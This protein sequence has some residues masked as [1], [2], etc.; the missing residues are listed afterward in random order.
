MPAFLCVSLLFLF[1]VFS[2]DR[3]YK[4]D[5]SIRRTNSY[6]EGLRIVTKKDGAD[7]WIMT[8]R[9]ADFTKDETTAR[10]DSVSMDIKKEGVL[11]NAENGTYNMDNKDLSLE[12]N[13]TIRAK[14]SIIRMKSLEW[15]P[16]RG[17]LTS[18]SNIRVENSRFTVEGEGLSAT[19][20]NKVTLMR[21]VRATFF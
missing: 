15:N 20:D 13:V 4:R 7:S 11:V 1:F 17:T 9:R 6:I 5:I 18:D 8:A 10:M 2:G 16:S 14:D 21:N 3:D 19:E 12:N